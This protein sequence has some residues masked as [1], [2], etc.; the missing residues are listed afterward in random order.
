[1]EN[2]KVRSSTVSRVFQQA[3]SVTLSRFQAAMSK[4]VEQ[5]ANSNLAAITALNTLFEDLSTK[6]RLTEDNAVL[7]NAQAGVDTASTSNPDRFHSQ[8]DLH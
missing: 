2:F 7:A 3:L 5:K 6:W 4:P 1:M 8:H